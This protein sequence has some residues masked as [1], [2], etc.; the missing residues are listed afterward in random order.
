MKNG[1]TLLALILSISFS[2]TAQ[3]E[4][5]VYFTDKNEVEFNPYTFFDK[6]AIDRRINH[7]IDLYNISDYPVN[8]NYLDA[9][10]SSV[11]ATE[12]ISRWFNAVS[13]FAYDDQIASMLQFPFVKHV[14]QIY[15]SN[16][17]LALFKDTAALVEIDKLLKEQTT[18]MEGDLF[19]SNHVSGKGV[20]VAVFD[21]GF[22]LVDKHKAFE[23]LR[24]NNKIIKT[25]DFIKRDDFVY[26]YGTHGRATL[27]CICGVYEGT[28]IG[29]ASDIEVMLA[30]TEYTKR[31]PFSEEKYW[32]AAAEWADKNG[33][34]IISS[35]LG[36]THHRY[37]ISDMDGKT[38][39]VTRAANMAAS[40]GM[41]VVNSMGNEGA[42]KW[43]YMGAPADADSVL[44]IGAVHPNTY[45][46]TS[47]SSFGPTSDKRLKPNVTAFGHVKAAGS[48]GLTKTQ[49]TSFSCPLVAGFAACV[50]QLNPKM[51]NMELF[52]AI[53]K[54]GN[55]YPY[56][57]YAHGYGIPQAS[58]FL[59]TE[60]ESEKTIRIEEKEDELIIII[61]NEQLNTEHN[62]LYYHVANEKGYLDKY[63]VIEVYQKEALK[64]DRNSFGKGQIL[65]VHYDGNTIEYKL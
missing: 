52:H 8:E 13:V 43:E 18:S 27:S 38:S 49:G 64:L 54:S 45:Y 47:F 58:Y 42:G 56:F 40:K 53:E 22:K 36:Y 57:D 46:H 25:Y 51:T 17:T 5:W 2:L 19:E 7:K 16:G 65:R 12:I 31:E 9:V 4:Y 3:N 29:L 59:E 26:D 20:R 23:H 1:I 33:A 14:E 6:K 32:L 35:S 55:L 11:E 60:G 28:R 34:D 10:A 15:S 50:L 63:A 44:S 24:N 37:F 30:R 62:Y 41:L 21:N 48:K 39:L 61:L